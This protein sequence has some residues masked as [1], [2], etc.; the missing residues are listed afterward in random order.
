MGK[1]RGIRCVLDQTIGHPS[2]QNQIML[3]EQELH[4]EFFI[5]SYRPFDQD[6]IDRQNAEIAEADLVVVGSEFCARTMTENGCPL[7]KILVVNYG[8]DDSLFPVERPQRSVPATRALECLFVGEIGP[9]K[10][11]A[12]LLQAFM[13]IPVE[14][15]NLTLGWALGHSFRYL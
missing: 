8:Y 9:R 11:A 3:Q 12:Y 5:D 1:K 13:N 2:A 6:C 4:P 15:A 14:K 7:E 10:G